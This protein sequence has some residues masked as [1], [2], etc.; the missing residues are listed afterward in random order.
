LAF[1]PFGVHEERYFSAGQPTKL[2]RDRD[3][4]SYDEP[5]SGADE[6]AAAM[7]RMSA[8]SASPSAYAPRARR[9]SRS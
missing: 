8:P 9:A 2:V 4:E 3:A 1:D 7:A 5:P 6:V